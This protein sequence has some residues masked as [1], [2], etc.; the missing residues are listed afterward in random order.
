MNARELTDDENA[1]LHKLEDTLKK[2]ELLSKRIDDVATI[3]MEG[4]I[5]DST[6]Q[7][8]LVEKIGKK[9]NEQDKK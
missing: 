5:G 6:F 3:V 7:E 9:P 2:L 1:S 8:R 4:T